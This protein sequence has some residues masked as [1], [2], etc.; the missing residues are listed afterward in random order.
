MTIKTL[1]PPSKGEKIYADAVLPGFG[2]R[3]SEG[4]TKSFV[5]THGRLR[6]RETIGR[7]GILGL[8]DARQEAKRRL[9][10]YTLGKTQPRAISWDTA[11]NRYLEDVQK[12]QK[13]R[14]YSDYKRF[15]AKHFRLGALAM[16]DITPDDIQ[17]RVD[18]LSATPVEQHHAFT[19][20]RTFLRWAHRK[21]Y[22]NN[23][24]M[25]RMKSDHRYKPRARILTDEELKKVWNAAGDD[26]FGNIV[27]LL[28]LTGQRVGE[29]SKLSPDMCS[30]SAITLPA[31][32]TK[33]GREH[34][35]PVGTITLRLLIAIPFETLPNFARHKAKLDEASGVYGWVLHDLR[36]T[37]A[38]GL[39]SLGVPIPVV[40]KLLNHV[41]G[42]FAGIVGVYH[43]Y[44][45]AKEMREAVE[46]WQ[47][48][49]QT[50]TA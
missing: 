6:K 20:V 11:V 30:A 22:L 4:G 10:E 43:R 19:V 18:R 1:K 14:T 5:L 47:K 38:S 33:N 12:R 2:V 28:I 50:L 40:E 13:P 49:I 27:K 46:L 42:T 24:P 23:N 21:H 15:L 8:A 37:F 16:A 31:W 7:V 29:V 32:L 9:A 35:F 48:H 44:D 45:Y 34:T 17:T 26:S 41:S 25:D 36:R 3:V 39:A